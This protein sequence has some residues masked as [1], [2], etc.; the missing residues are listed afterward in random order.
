VE[1]YPT[2]CDVCDLPAPDG[3]EGTRA[4]PVMDDPSRPWKK[5][6]FTNVRRDTHNVTVRT[7]EWRCSQCGDSRR[8]ELY[9]LE[10]DSLEVTNLAYDPAYAEPRQEMQRL[11]AAGWQGG[12]ISFAAAAIRRAPSTSQA[13]LLSRAVRCYYW[14]TTRRGHT[15]KERDHE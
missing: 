10:D 11:L 2:L 9:D 13:Q 15:A 4:V 14:G 12:A 6:V 1:L 3:L 7:D 5:A 8:R